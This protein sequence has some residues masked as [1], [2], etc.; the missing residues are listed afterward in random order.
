M[1]QN[2]DNYTFITSINEL[3]K[4]KNKFILFSLTREDCHESNAIM[5]KLISIE[6]TPNDFTREKYPISSFN[7]IIIKC[8]HCA[9][10]YGFCKAL[11]ANTINGVTTVKR[12]I[13]GIRK[14][15]HEEIKSFM[16]EWR[17]EKFYNF[18]NNDL[19]F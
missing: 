18:V 11:S 7:D 6:K 4:Y 13:I 2:N 3:Q 17:Y 16:K 19:P 5:A 8:T 15:T 12:K 10:V 9:Y 14:P 1:E